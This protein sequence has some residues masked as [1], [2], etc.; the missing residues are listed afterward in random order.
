M[1]K[2]V[3][4]YEEETRLPRTPWKFFP[5]TPFY[6]SRCYIKTKMNIY[7]ARVLLTVFL[8]IQSLFNDSL[9]FF[10]N[11]TQSGSLVYHHRQTNMYGNATQFGDIEII[12]L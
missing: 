8:Y 3:E 2:N 12:F 6:S 11:M 1:K 10:E 9:V 7:T 5:N 4:N